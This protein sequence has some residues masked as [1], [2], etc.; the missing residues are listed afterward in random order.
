MITQVTKEIHRFLE[1]HILDLQ[2]DKISIASSYLMNYEKYVKV[3]HLLNSYIKNIEAFIDE[4]NIQDGEHKP[5]FVIIGSTVEIEDSSS[6][7]TRR[8]T[9]TVTEGSAQAD[10]APGSGE[11]VSFLSDTGIRLLLREEG[12]SVTI[13]GRENETEIKIVSI[14]YPL[15]L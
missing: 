11:P 2:N 15:N 1:L 6:H 8:L 4:V 12:Q 14:S 3:L 7:E 10:D 5:P 13:K 9:I